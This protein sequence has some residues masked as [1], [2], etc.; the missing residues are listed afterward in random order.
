LLNGADSFQR[1]ILDD[2][3]FYKHAL[4]SVTDDDIVMLENAGHGLHFE[5]PVRVRKLVHEFLLR[6]SQ[7]L[8]NTR[9]MQKL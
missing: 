5:Q 9:R 2:A 1:E 4:S 7:S 8:K 3:K 6:D